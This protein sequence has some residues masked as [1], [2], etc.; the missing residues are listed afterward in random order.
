LVPSFSLQK[1][2]IGV[3]EQIREAGDI[4]S[5]DH[6]NKIINLEKMNPIFG[7][8]APQVAAS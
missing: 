7:I 3:H 8:I 4:S 2:A 6:K 1:A 5:F